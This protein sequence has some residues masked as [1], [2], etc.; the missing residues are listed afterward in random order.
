MFALRSQRWNT[1]E[2]VRVETKQERGQEREKEEHESVR[3][4][5]LTPA[6]PSPREGPE[7]P[8]AGEGK[9]VVFGGRFR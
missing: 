2:T 9:G 5:I 1:G 7:D 4:E 3:R 8:G 6:D